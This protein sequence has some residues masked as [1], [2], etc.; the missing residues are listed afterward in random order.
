MWEE[1]KSKSSSERECSN[2]IAIMAASG[3]KTTIVLTSLDVRKMNNLDL[4]GEAPLFSGS[5]LIF[6]EFPKVDK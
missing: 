5:L 6:L 1:E 2:E 3:K 4:Q